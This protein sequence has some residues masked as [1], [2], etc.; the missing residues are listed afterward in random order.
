MQTVYLTGPVTNLLSVLRILIEI[1]SH[2]HAKGWEGGTL[3][4]F[5]FGTFIS[6]FQSDGMGSMAVKGLKISLSKATI[7]HLESHTRQERSELFE[8][9]EK[10]YKKEKEAIN[11]NRHSETSGL[12]FC[13]AV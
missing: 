9:R 12:D 6:R 3:N 4:N 2:T 8:S 11:N 10:R 13:N 7:T 5:K 1:L